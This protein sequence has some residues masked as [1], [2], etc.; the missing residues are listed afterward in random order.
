MSGFVAG[1]PAVDETMPATTY[2][3]QVSTTTHNTHNHNTNVARLPQEAEIASLPFVDQVCP[4]RKVAT[5]VDQLP[6]EGDVLVH[7]KV[8]GDPVVP[9]SELP[10]SHPP[11]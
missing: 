6:A 2:Q 11:C 5:I 3:Q 9:K 8:S 7:C 1:P 10:L 4:H